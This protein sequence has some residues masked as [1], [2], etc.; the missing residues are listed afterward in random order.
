MKT[1]S[2]TFAVLA[3]RCQTLAANNS[4]NV[5]LR[6]EGFKLH[7]EWQNLIT[8]ASAPLSMEER[9]GVNADAD[10]LFNRMRSF[11]AYHTSQLIL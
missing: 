2:P 6:S 3:A 7:A 8:R 11:M 5:E 4:T 1:E 10:T 9:R